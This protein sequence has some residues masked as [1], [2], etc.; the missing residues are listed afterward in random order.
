MFT[1]PDSGPRPE[2]FQFSRR[3]NRL[4]DDAINGGQA[5]PEFAVAAPSN[6]RQADPVT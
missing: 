1:T 6:G 3:L 5:F 4:H 2:R